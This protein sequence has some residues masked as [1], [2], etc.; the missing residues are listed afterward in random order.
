MTDPIRLKPSAVARV[1]GAAAL[2]LALLST[3]AY[4]F[5][6]LT[7]HDEVMGLLSLVYLDKERNFPTIFSVLILA[8]V[9]LIAAVI[10]TL[11][12]KHRAPDVTR[13]AV[14]SVGFLY[15]AFDEALSLHERLSVPV[16][17][18]LGSR[19]GLHHTFWAVPILIVVILLGLYFLPFLRRLPAKTRWTLLAAGGIYVGGAIGVEFLSGTFWSGKEDLTYV[20]I[21]TLEESCEMAGVILCIYGL[22]RYLA[23]TYGEVR[24]LLGERREERSRA[25]GT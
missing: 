9:S 15:L 20:I 8:M 18:I 16:K 12:R 2:V 25:V 24:F 3:A 1:L 10:A 6:F 22:L 11:A 13:W 14:L 21:V 7:G 23:D 5:R 4:L 19:T 17:A